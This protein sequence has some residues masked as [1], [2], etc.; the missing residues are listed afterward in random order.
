MADGSLARRYARALVELGQEAGKV[1]PLAADLVVFSS[2]LDEGDGL[3]RSVLG[4]PGLTTV[5]RRA[6]LDKVLERMRIDPLVA[7]TLRLVVDNSRFEHL[8]EIIRAYTQ[9]A[10]EV[11]GRVRATVTTARP[12]DPA[13]ASRV[14]ASLSSTTGKDVILTEEVDPDVLGGMV[15]RIGDTVYDASIKARLTNLEQALLRAPGQA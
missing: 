5:E 4:N 8:D 9:M 3:L 10:D 11:A 7:N 1:D 14:K 13:M 2:L 12:L 6:V 15:V